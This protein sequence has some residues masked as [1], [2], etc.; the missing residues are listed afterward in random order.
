MKIFAAG[1]VNPLEGMTDAQSSWLISE[2]MAGNEDAIEMFV[3]QYEGNVFRLALSMVGDDAEANEI[4]QETFLA[5]LRALP[6]YQERQS[7]KAWLYTIALNQSRS[8]LRQR[9]VSERLKS[10]L[11]SIFR[12]EIQKQDTP[13]EAIVR[14]EKGSDIWHALNQLDERHRIIVILRYFH[15]LPIAEISQILAIPEGT[16]HSRLH[17]AREKLRAALKHTYGE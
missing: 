6:S 5:A 16:I 11:A 17:S 10:S 14:E 7:L 13:E 3:R 12:L 4:T 1:G 15:E 8:H 2:C 9:K